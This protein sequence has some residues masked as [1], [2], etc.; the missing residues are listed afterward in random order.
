MK[1]EGAYRIT[2]DI[3]KSIHPEIR[4][5]LAGLFSIWKPDMIV[6]VPLHTKK[7]RSR[8]FNQAELLCVFLVNLLDIK[9]PIEKDLI[10]RTRFTKPQSEYPSHHDRAKNIADAFAL[11]QPTSSISKK[12]ILLVDDIW[13]SGATAKEITKTLKYNGASTVYMFSIAHG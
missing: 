13:T 3:Q 12:T 8:G 11:T 7:E 4:Q 6:P 5:T 2:E 1:Y 10:K 9:T